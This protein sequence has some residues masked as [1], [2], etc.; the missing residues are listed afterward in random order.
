MSAEDMLSFLKGCTPE[1]RLGFM[2]VNQCAPVLKNV[3]VSNL[4]TVR[5]GGW[6]KVRGYLR[7]SRVICVLL[8][9]DQGKEVLFLYR[10]DRLEGHLKR[11]EVRAFLNGRGYGD[12]QV[13]AVLKLLRRRYQQY[14]GAGREFPHE[15]GV[16][17]G[18][19]VADVEGFIENRGENSL[20]AGYWKVYSDLKGA[21]RTFRVY[22][23]AK[24]QAMREI[25]SGCPLCQ[26]AVNG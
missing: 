11:P 19:P 18:Y 23:E 3:K 24:E 6:Q 16:L 22:D 20:A 25:I 1:A 21:E 10:Y 12:C 9:A 26:V 8:Y 7:K 15:L 4:I 14:A 13:A 17:L 2:V 5:P